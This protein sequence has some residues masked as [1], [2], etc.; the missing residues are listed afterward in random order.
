MMTDA[1]HSSDCALR[2]DG[3]ECTCGYV[4]PLS[5]KE[6]ETVELREAIVKARIIAAAYLYETG[7]DN[8][9]APAQSHEEIV[10]MAFDLLTR[11]LLTH[12]GKGKK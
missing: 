9:P 3:K 7:V 4:K 11:S 12:L 1:F 5:K 10:E 8:A 2:R 6:K